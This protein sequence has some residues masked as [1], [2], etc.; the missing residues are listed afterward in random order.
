MTGCTVVICDL[1][2]VGGVDVRGSSPGT[3]ET[4]LLSPYKKIEKINAIL[5]GGGSA[6]G[7][8]AADGV[9]NYLEEM[10][11]GFK[12]G[13]NTVPIVPAAI[14][15]DLNVGDGR[16]RPSSSEGYIACENSS[17]GIVQTGSVGAGTG[18]TVAKVLGLNSS[19]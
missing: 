15:F 3:R 14:L 6:Y 17:H 9:M 19:I 4:D 8:A 18:A 11:K 16:I 1:G 7:L 5:I 13:T 2:A 12:I 10:G